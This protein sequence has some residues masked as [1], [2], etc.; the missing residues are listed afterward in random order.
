MSDIFGKIF[1]KDKHQSQ[2]I[3]EKEKCSSPSA[4]KSTTSLSVSASAKTSDFCTYKPATVVMYYVISFHFRAFIPSVRILRYLW[5]PYVIG[6]AIIF[7]ALW[8]LSYSIYLSFFPRLISAAAGWMSTIH[9][10]ALVRI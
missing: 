9:G 10:V 8:F 1:G 3:K 4:D 5:L 7:F 2:Q 6:Q